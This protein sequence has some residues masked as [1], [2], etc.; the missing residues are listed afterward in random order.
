VAPYVPA[1][2]ATTW[3]LYVEILLALVGPVAVVHVEI[4][5][6]PVIAQ[7]PVATGAI[8]PIGP[9]TVAVNEIVVPSVAVGESATT[10]TVGTT[11]VT[12]VDAPDVGATL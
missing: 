4:P 9:E 3:Q 10:D 6:T 1:R 2:E 8:D 5:L 12:R 7:I 11:P